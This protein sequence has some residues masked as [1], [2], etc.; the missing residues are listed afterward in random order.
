MKLRSCLT[1]LALL[2]FISFSINAQKGQ[3]VLHAGVNFTRVS[4]T[5]GRK[6]DA[7]DILSTFQFGLSGEYH[8]GAFFYI[9]PG[10]S[11]TGKGSKV[12][13]GDPD[14]DLTWYKATSNPFYVEVPV[15]VVIKTPGKNNLF[16]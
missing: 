5:N 2:L 6:Y 11:Y 14:K 13:D 3:A 15:N 10:V 16:L 7:S 9:R 8:L 1:L 12:S 4:L